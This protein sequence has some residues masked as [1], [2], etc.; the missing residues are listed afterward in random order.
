MR[1]KGNFTHAWN[2]YKTHAWLRDEVMPLSG[3]SHDPFGGWAATLAD[4]LD[5]LWIMGLY[6][7][8][9]EAVE[10]IQA[11]DFSSCA[12]GE[13]NVFE[14]TIRYLGGFIAAYDL[15]GEKYPTLLRKAT[16]MG[17]MLYKA[18]DTPN[19]MPIMR[20]D[21][22]A[23]IGGGAQEAGDFVLVSEIGSHT[24]EF[25]RLSQITGD[26]RYY[27]AVQRIMDIFEQQQDRTK[28][29]GMWPVV[30]NAKAADFANYGGFTIGGMADS[31]YEYLPKQHILIGGATQ[32][33]RRLYDYS[34]TAIKRNIFFRPMTK[35]GEDVRLAGQ[36]NSDGRTLVKELKT[37]P[38]AQHLGCFAGGMV[39]IAAKI[40]QNDDDLALAQKLVEGCLWAYEIMPLGIMQEIFHAVPCDDEKSCPWD[41]QKW[42]D[43]V[44][45]EHEGQ[46]SAE[47]KIKN[48]RL[49]PGVVK[50]D[51]ARYILRPEAIE[52]VFILYRITGDPT[53]VERAWNMFNAII[54]YT[55]TD[56]AHAALDDC[57]VPNPPKADRMESFWVAETL[58][59]FYLIFSDPSLIS[60]DDFVLNTEAH[61]LRRPS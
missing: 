41:E 9:N 49:P 26:P 31:L 32:Q 50:I 46:E 29:P 23:A 18:F 39:G 37:E 24:L 11:I 40:F 21:F 52:S 61:P 33:Y 10:A 47:A 55:I 42:H 30:V 8:F 1:S 16:E 22:K 28:L 51:D 54:K 7:D 44:D 17:D 60:L 59:Y 56:I 5:T 12:L 4:S 27:D 43:A 19:R 6:N 20:W 14:T 48:R 3:G 2:G 25:T 13:L 45:K 36:V 58:K 35:N 38:Q 15:S 53:L 57:T 34:M